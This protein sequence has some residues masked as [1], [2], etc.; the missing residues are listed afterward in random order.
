MYAKPD[1]KANV[2]TILRVLQYALW[3][4]RKETLLWGGHQGEFFIK[5]TFEMGL[6]ELVDF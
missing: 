5:V 1:I 2:I 6:D 3:V 4:Q